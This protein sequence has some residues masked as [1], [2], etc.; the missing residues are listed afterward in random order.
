M[1]LATSSIFAT[2]GAER[3]QTNRVK[4]RPGTAISRGNGSGA[5]VM[6]IRLLGTPT[7]FNPRGASYAY[8]T[9]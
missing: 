1:T 6:L 7:D 5:G 4:P 2:I 9:D 8:A 3:V